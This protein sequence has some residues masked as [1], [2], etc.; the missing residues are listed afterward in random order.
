MSTIE[1]IRQKY[2]EK[3]ALLGDLVVQQRRLHSAAEHA[4]REIEQLEQDARS[5]SAEQA[6]N[7]TEPTSNT[8]VASTQ[9]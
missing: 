6:T 4:I 7:T 2:A 3:C 5:L 9:E 1:E 8:P